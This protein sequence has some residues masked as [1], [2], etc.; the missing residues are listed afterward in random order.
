MGESVNIYCDES[1]HLENDHQ[2]I[3]ALGA[4]W[5]P[6]EKRAEIFSRIKEIKIKHALP[7][8]FEI[9]WTKVSAAK[10]QFYL[11]LVDYF[12]DDDDLHFRALIVPDKSILDHKAFSQDHDTFYY[13]MYFDLLK[14]I[15]KPQGEYF[16]YLDYKDT[17]GGTK[18]SQL[19]D[20][21]CNSKYDF[22]R[23]II[24][25]VQIV[26]SHEV[27]LLQLTDL[28][29]GIVSYHAR[30]LAQNPGKVQLVKRM[31]QRSRYSLEKTTL[32]QEQKVNLFFWHPRGGSI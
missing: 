31:Q 4:V 6:T 20:V 18:A 12:F 28:F 8:T 30:K 10:I 32:P 27:H 11:D 2:N 29:L 14:I 23:Q 3:M 21:L 26:P 19:Q 24:R 15:I 7:S 16:I 13:K 5:C 1:C 9:K 25:R 17:H 22:S